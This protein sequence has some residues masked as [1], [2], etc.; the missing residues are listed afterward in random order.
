MRQRV[1]RYTLAEHFC[2]DVRTIDAWAR[3]GVIPPPHYLPGSRVPFWYQDETMAVH[4]PTRRKL[5]Q[6]A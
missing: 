3:K 1:R 5:E 2:V 4:L 6:A